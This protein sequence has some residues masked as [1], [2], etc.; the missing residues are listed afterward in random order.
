[1]LTGPGCLIKATPL[2]WAGS[3]QQAFSHHAGTT[4]P[5]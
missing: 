4:T 3:L 5:R 1:V 2:H